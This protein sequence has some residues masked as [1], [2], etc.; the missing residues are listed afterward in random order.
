M[1]TLLALTLIFAADTQPKGDERAT[2][3]IANQVQKE[4]LSLNNY[5]VFDAINFGIYGDKVILKGYAS[6]P[7][8]KD[9]A[10]RVVKG[11]EGVGSV[12]NRIQVLPLSPNDDRLRAAVYVSI[13]GHP[14]LQRYTSNRAGFYVS[15]MRAITGIVND[16]PIGWHAIHIVVNQG[17]VTLTGVVDNPGDKA[18]A[19]IVAN[20]IPGVFSVDND[21]LVANDSGRKSTGG[22]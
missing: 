6:R 19:G 5:G 4:I 1:P 9:S 17:N 14:T 10:E 11:I 16:P 8:L 12:D 2:L 21:L 15:R 22:K 7:V 13:Y 3:R 18:I 20:Q